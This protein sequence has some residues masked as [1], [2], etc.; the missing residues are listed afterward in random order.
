MKKT[1]YKKS[2][3]TIPLNIRSLLKLQ[4]FALFKI[5]ALPPCPPTRCQIH[6]YV[7]IV[8]TPRYIGNRGVATP[9]YFGNRGVATPR[10]FGQNIH[11]KNITTPNFINA[12]VLVLIS[13]IF[14]PF[15]K[16]SISGLC[17]QHF[18]TSRMYT[19]FLK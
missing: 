6:M 14:V 13:K 2:C 9:R 18:N 11:G 5:R 10:Y 8:A 15:E 7:G 1:K 3:E 17:N 19:K 16:K 12:H 4:R